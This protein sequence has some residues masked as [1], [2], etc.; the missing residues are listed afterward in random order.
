MGVLAAVRL[1]ICY[2]CNG[3]ECVANFLFG[4][5]PK[6]VD[7][8]RRSQSEVKEVAAR[9]F[10]ELCRQDRADGRRQHAGRQ[11]VLQQTEAIG[12]LEARQVE[13]GILEKLHLDKRGATARLRCDL[14]HAPDSDRYRLDGAGYEALD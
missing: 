5:H 2:A 4:D 11:F 10:P 7:R 1:D 8:A 12:E 3:N 6:L 14:V 9:Q 13:V